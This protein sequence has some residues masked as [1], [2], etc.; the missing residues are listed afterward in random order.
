M[1][2]MNRKTK[3]PNE[4]G[5]FTFRNIAL[6]AFGLSGMTALIYEVVW[7]RML[8]LIFGSTVYAVAT[9]LTA[10]MAGLALGSY[11]MG[12]RCD[13]VED[14]PLYFGLFELGIGIYG[15]LFILALGYVQYPYFFLYKILHAH[16]WLFI[17]AQFL[18]YFLVLLVPTTM[19]GAIFPIVSKIFTQNMDE[20]GKDIGYVYAVN[21][22]GSVIGPFLAGFILIPIVGIKNTAL[23][24]A[25]VNMLLAFIILRFSSL[26]EEGKFFLPIMFAFL[27]IGSQAM[28]PPMLI[29][30]WFVGAFPD[31]AAAEETLEDVDVLFYREGPYSTVTVVHTLGYIGLKSDGRGEAST[32]PED[33]RHQFLLAY[34]P[35]LLHKNPEKVLDIGVGAGFTLGAIENFDSKQIDA[36]EIDPAILEA[37]EKFFSRFNNDALNDPRIR[38]FTTDGRN[39]LLMTEGKYDVIVSAP[40]HPLT[41]GVSHLFTKEFFELSKAHLNE[42]G[43]YC[44][45]VPGHRFSPEEHKIVVK[46][47]TSVFPHTILWINNVDALNDSSQMVDSFLIGSMHPI[48]IDRERICE[49][50]NENE[51]IKGD[52]DTIGVDSADEFFSLMILDEGG[53]VSY[54]ADEDRLNTDDFPIIEFQAPK[55]LL[56]D[57]VVRLSDIMS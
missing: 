24:A 44:Q 30:A 1:G 19:F 38:I 21:S 54:A 14:L 40:S 50:V 16:F 10:F 49:I 4:R 48:E 46:T 3:A 33:L 36:V 41:S 5:I 17:L 43:I 28:I 7:A 52:L 25:S 18:L 9:M 2:K 26:K 31:I 53:V 22:F 37:S 55:S 6:I 45:W 57:S 51:K 39:Y 47:F 20:L 34:I 35:M 11:L 29:N 12:K 8:S 56:E 13:E 23:F 27:L 42:D 15:I 32:L